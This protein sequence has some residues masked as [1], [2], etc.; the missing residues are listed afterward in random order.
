MFRALSTC[1]RHHELGLGLVEGDNIIV[2]VLIAREP[3]PSRQLKV[4]DKIG[5]AAIRFLRS[6]IR[7]NTCRGSGSSRNI[8]GSAIL[9][10][11]LPSTT[12]GTRGTFITNIGVPDIKISLKSHSVLL[13]KFLSILN[14]TLELLETADGISIYDLLLLDGASVL[15]FVGM[16]FHNAFLVKSFS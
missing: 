14:L 6:A 7:N 16:G 12:N 3:H 15:L 9:T 13:N 5:C 11:P 1:F 10:A 2:N 8:G 4:F